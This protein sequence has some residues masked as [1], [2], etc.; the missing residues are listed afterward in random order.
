MRKTYIVSLYLFAACIVS[1]QDPAAGPAFDPIAAAELE[2]LR[3]AETRMVMELNLDRAE[4]LQKSKQF[5][6]AST[7]Y[8]EAIALARKLGNL[9]AVEKEI[10]KARRGIVYS[11]LRLALDFQ[12]QNLFQ[13]ADK[14]AAKAQVYDPDSKKLRNFREFNEE[15]RVAHLGQVPSPEMK[16]AVQDFRNKRS[17][18]LTLIRDGKAYY[19][20]RQ[21]DQAEAKLKEA[22][23]LDP[24]SDV[25][26]YYLRLIL[27]AKYDL[28][29][30]ARDHTFH[31]RVIEVA[32]AWNRKTQ[33]DLPQP[34]PY[35]LTNSSLPFL[36]HTSKGAQRIRHKINS[37]II[38]EIAYD[39]LTL[40]EVVQDLIEQVKA[41]DP[42]KDGINFLI[43]SQAADTILAGGAAGGG[44][45]GGA[46]DGADDLG[47]GAVGG[48][49]VLDAMGNPVAAPPPL[50]GGGAPGVDLQQVLINIKLPLFNL[51]LEHVLDAI[52][53]TADQPIKYIVEEYAIVFTPKLQDQAPLFTRIFKVNPDTF[54]SGLQNVTSS[55]ILFV[56]GGGGQQGGGGGGGQGG[57]TCC[58]DSCCGSGRCRRR[59]RCCCWR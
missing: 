16:A 28:E 49:P 35:F 43:N 23:K 44:G 10:D 11:R 54:V 9:Q 55:P 45:L 58:D 31:E 30:R 52:I 4:K 41:N 20:L 12:D 53:K 47:G 56:A 40:D 26:Y 39:G 7:V 42:D 34:N 29:G 50:P 51:K 22:V 2:A 38:P 33:K 27:E 57:D 13:E 3:R 14:E 6:A 18:V 8:E 36:T 32:E 59:R 17:D 15:V 24:Q 25:A 1:A 48:A 37:I 46:D 5:D 19:E 21:F